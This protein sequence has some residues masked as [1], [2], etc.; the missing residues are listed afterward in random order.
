VHSNVCK[1][2]DTVAQV[3]DHLAL[4]QSWIGEQAAKGRV[5]GELYERVQW[6]GNVLPRL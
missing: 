2:P 5:L 4:L 3:F 1:T 6:A